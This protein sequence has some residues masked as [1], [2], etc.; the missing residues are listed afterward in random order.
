VS[1]RVVAEWDQTGWWV[2]TVPDV[3]GAITQCRRLDQVRADAAEV[4]EIQTG[5]PVDPADIEVEP[6][7]P[8]DVGN[9]AEEARRLRAENEELKR[10]ADERTRVAVEMLHRAGFTL[11]D[12]G[13]LTGLSFQR[14]QQIVKAS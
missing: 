6:R 12:I 7:L 5:E 10:R 9:V 4:I 14:A 8:G 13:E 2:V 3:P 11:R 1:H